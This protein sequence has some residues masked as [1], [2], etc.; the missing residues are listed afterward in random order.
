MG[1]ILHDW[2][3][4]RKMHLIRAAYDA[5]PEGGAFIAIENLID[6]AR[7]ENAFGLLMSLN[8]LIEFGDAFD[9]TGADFAGWCRGGRL[10]RGRGRAARRS[11]QRRHRVQVAIVPRIISHH[12]GRGRVSP[13]VVA[14]CLVLAG[15]LLAPAAASAALSFAP[16]QTFAVGTHP[17]SV[18]VGDFNGDGRPDLAVTNA[19]DSTVSVLLGNGAGS[20]GSQQTFAVGSGPFSV[21]VGDFNGD[22]RPDLAVTNDS[23]STVSV[24]LGN[25]AGS[26]GSQQTFAVGNTPTSVAVGDFNG[27][28]KPD[29]AV[30][31]QS[32]ST[33]SV[34][35]GHGDGTF[36][37]QP[38][39]AVG[40]TPRSVAVGDFNGDGKP[41]LAVAN[42][43]DS[44]VSVL[45]GNGAGSFGSQQTFA[46]GNSPV[47]VAV[48]DFN[49]DGR[50]DLAVANA[51][52]STVSVLL[53]NGAGSFGSQQTFAVGSGPV[54]V[55]VG[56]FNGDGRPDLAVTND[57]DDTV[58]VLLGNGAGSFGSQ[59]TF[60]VGNTP[61]SV[62]VGDFNGDGK[63]DLAIAN[64]F[65]KTVSALTNT[66]TGFSSAR[67]GGAGSVLIDQLRLTGPSLAGDRLAE[68]FNTT[69][70]VVSVGG[71]QLQGSGGG[72]GTIP[73]GTVIP[74]HGHLLLTGPGNSYSLSGYA[75][76]NGELFDTGWSLAQPAFGG[77]RLVAPGGAVIDR[78]GFA[79]APAGFFAGTGLSAPA[80][81]PGSQFA[82]VRNVSAGR[83][84]NTSNNAADFS[85]LALSGN[86]TA[87]GS[88]VL[89]AP[90][91]G[92]LVSPIVHND[93][94]Q[95]G[96]LDPS[97]AAGSSP[98]RIFT[99]G[100]PG[101][102]II[103]RTITNCAGQPRT[104]ACAGA[105]AGSTAQTVTRLRLRITG[106]TTLDSPGAGATQAVLKADSSTGE[107]GLPGANT[108]NGST[109][110]IGLPLDSPSVSGS[111]GLGS[112]LDC[113]PA[114]ARRRARP[115]PVHQRRVQVRCRPG[116]HVQL[117]LQRRAMTSPPRA[118]RPTWCA[119]VAVSSPPRPLGS[120]RLT[121]D[122]LFQTHPRPRSAGSRRSPSA[123][124]GCG[125]RRPRAPKTELGRLL[126]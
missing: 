67:R 83:P 12:T 64:F 89:G 108:C 94:L 119:A 71:W 78:V 62:A 42:A 82:W 49:G 19:S 20:F 50:P 39:L 86:D 22:G 98:N 115:R 93:I 9:F 91:P 58:G 92:N 51:S 18:A 34:L 107:T 7:R 48:G 23:D 36:A 114:A 44:T 79:G 55:A 126:Q 11:G 95:S 54:S 45:L 120:G 35:L 90:G 106:L 27:D 112:T 28:G 29:L 32:D 75:A 101:T 3:L 59:Q 8:M 109:N 2:N 88:P 65:D 110:V 41:D 4:E 33:V 24:L 47:S 38:T 70:A 73:Q 10:S 76:S 1:L 99:A 81:L 40:S 77:V 87:H 117:R 85:Y 118:A 111:G 69:A 97:A 37:A 63:P 84:V 21:A 16:Q 14:A 25:G 100:S 17:R 52:D 72:F 104:G 102:L 74:A 13:A 121:P 6:D 124:C 125:T 103:N 26:F 61:T 56:D 116:R 53:G 31:N 80:A 123:S 30:T 68:L 43:G 96:L 122:A 57:S 15:V 113:D 5:L 60:A 46:V 66:S 105:P